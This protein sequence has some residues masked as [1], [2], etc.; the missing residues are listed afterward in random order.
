MTTTDFIG[1]LKSERIL[2]EGKKNDRD[3]L[4]LTTP[5][6][7]NISDTVT[8]E[9]KSSYEPKKEKGGVLV[10][11]PTKVGNETLLTVNKVIFLTNISKT[12]E[13]SYLPDPQELQQALLETLSTS[14]EK[15]LP[16]RFHTHPTHS[17]NPVNE[18]FNYIFQSNSSDQ[19]QLVSDTPISIGDINLLLPR[20]IV[21]CN[22]KSADR[23][24]IGFYNGLIAPLE[25]DTHRKEQSQKA[26]ETIMNIVS[27]WTEEGNNKW[28]LVGGGL[29][30]AILVIRYNRLAIPLI[31]LL[32]TM[33]PMFINDQHGQPKYFAQVR[34][35]KV[36]IDIP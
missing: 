23:M 22:G 15:T 9:L 14:K 24:F 12:P 31:L 30:L 1:Q 25:F 16:L 35:G 20:S 2:I 17:D 28:W 18:I 26:I 7:V 32:V 4:H 3:Y 27:E 36:S 33:I 13:N 21:L 29:F 5:C 10:A 11:K 34:T 6:K 8:T 19:D